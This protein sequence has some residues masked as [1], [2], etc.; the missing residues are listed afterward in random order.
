MPDLEAVKHQL[1]NR[2]EPESKMHLDSLFDDVVENALEQKSRP[3]DSVGAQH[4]SDPEVMLAFYSRLFPFKLI[5]EWLNRSQTP[6]N[7]F[8]HREIAFTLQNDAYLRYNSFPTSEALR[9]EVL[10]LNPLRFEIGPVYSANPR[11]RKTLRKSVFKPIEKELVF[12]IDLTDYDEI[13][14]CCSKTTICQKCW[15]FVTTAIKVLDI[16]LRNDFGFKHI[17]WVYSGRRGAHAWICD[18]SGRT[19]DD[20]NRKAIATYFEVV[21]GGIN[22]GKKV[23][24]KRPLHPHVTRTF[25]ILKQSF[26]TDI[27]ENQDPFRETT[28]QD[29]LLQLL[30]DKALTEAL[31]KKWE[32]QSNRPSTNK[33]ND[34]DA[35]ARTRASPNL[36]PKLLVMAKQDIIL[37]Y[38]Y[39]R[40]DSEVTKHTNHLLKSPFCIH[41]GTG[42]ICVPINPSKAEDFN[43]LTVPTVTQLLAEVDATSSEYTEKDSDVSKTSLRPYIEEFQRFVDDLMKSEITLKRQRVEEVE[44]PSSLD[45]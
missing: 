39:P 25:D 36:D 21:K 42:R 1:E 3:A 6:S 2:D 32:T 44:R 22:A 31:R 40:L 16:A 11:D 29:R 27:L 14:T 24:L 43:P 20:A 38:M 26:Q 30:P 23:N 33:W 8:S 15:R 37:E 12:D 5:F 7:S 35:I 18:K 34:I 19:L 10:R 9:K 13:R 28:G 45:F 17:L 4:Y 41:P